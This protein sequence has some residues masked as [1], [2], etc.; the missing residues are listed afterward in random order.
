MIDRQLYDNYKDILRSELIPALGCT[1]PGAIAYGASKARALL[2]TMPVSME[3]WCSV[4]IVKN[5][6]GVIV[7]NSDG[8]RGIEAAAVLGMLAGDSQSDDCDLEVLNHTTASD[9]ARAKELLADNF[10]ICHLA[11]DTP[12]LYI[13]VVVRSSDHEAQIVIEDSHTNITE[14]ILD[15][16]PVTS[17]VYESE[18][19]KT[20]KLKDLLSV[21]NILEFADAL[22][23]KDG[24]ELFSA[25]IR[26]N[27]AIAEEGLSGNYGACV[28]RTLL[29]TRDSRSVR[30]R[31]VAKAA[32]GSDARMNGC[33]LPVVINSGSGNQGITVTVPVVEY[34]KAVGAD[35]ISLYRAMAV[36]NLISI[37]IKHHIGKLSAFCGA[38][39]ASCGS[40]A[41]VA[42]LQG[43][44]YVHICNTISNTLGNVGGIVCDGAKASCA[45]KIASSLEAA[46]LGYDM[47]KEDLCFSPGEGFVEDDIEETIDNIGK[48]GRYGM[49]NTDKEILHLMLGHKDYICD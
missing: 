13:K 10:C 14:R 39:S 46:F 43:A 36:S 45:A 24:E 37:H 4:N 28:G 12:N 44:D 8:M 9:I 5:V 32:A 17:V 1:E 2:G 20:E 42:Y 35:P 11:E 38:V 34:A 6:K 31:A 19:D 27:T 23:E 47:A 29:K 33:T 49:K 15:G 48:I 30:A 26:D 21:K 25:Q 7:P 41:A 3:I 22:T 40:G 18:E 16:K